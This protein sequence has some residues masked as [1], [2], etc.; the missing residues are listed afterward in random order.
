MLVTAFRSDSPNTLIVGNTWVIHH[1]P[2]VSRQD[3]LPIELLR[4]MEVWLPWWPIRHTLTVVERS[5]RWA[6]HLRTLIRHGH[7]VWWLAHKHLLLAHHLRQLLVL[8]WRLWMRHVKSG[9]Y[10]WLLGLRG[11]Y[12]V[13]LERWIQNLL[14]LSV[15]L[16]AHCLLLK[17]LK[18]SHSIKFFLLVLQDAAQAL[19]KLLLNHRWYW[20]HHVLIVRVWVWMVDWIGY[21]AN[22]GSSC[23]ALVSYV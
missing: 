9:W 23:L 6:H 18:L 19:I 16:V 17:L 3:L 8:C 15:H 14:L 22:W 13:L 7:S 10:L 5:L 20:A 2:T 11:H 21:V 4:W 1:V 12:G